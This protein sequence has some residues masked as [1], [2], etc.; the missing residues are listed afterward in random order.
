MTNQPTNDRDGVVRHRL[1]DER[2]SVTK[3]FR[4]PMPN[5]EEGPKHLDLYVNVG[6]Y[7]DGRPGE[8]FITA[9]KQGSFISGALDGL[10][11]M[12]S[13]ALQHGTPIEA[14][15]RQ[16]KGTRFEPSGWYEGH[17]YTSVCDMIARWLELRFVPTEL[18]VR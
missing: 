3:H 2:K 13:L 12:A 7:P 6:F 8:I 16:L 1:D 17:N 10:A 5:A 15:V 14:I 11:K 18:N 9:S 4:L